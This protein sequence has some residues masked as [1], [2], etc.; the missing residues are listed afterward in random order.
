[1]WESI[2]S[3]FNWQWI[4]GSLGWSIVGAVAIR[5]WVWLTGKEF[6]KRKAIAFWI[7]A[8]LSFFL[9]TLMITSMS[10]AGRRPQLNGMI[11]GINT[12][13]MQMDKPTAYVLAVVAIRN[14]GAP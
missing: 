2:W 5:A 12:G 10:T 1:M 8:P 6:P 7:I 11:E 4:A 9:L 13:T 14:T 3:V